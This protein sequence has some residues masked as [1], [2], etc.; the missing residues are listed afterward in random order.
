MECSPPK[1]RD[2]TDI[3]GSR[4]SGRVH[5]TDSTFCPATSRCTPQNSPCNPQ[6]CENTK[7][8]PRTT[9]KQGVRLS[10]YLGVPKQQ[11]IVLSHA[12]QRWVGSRW[13]TQTSLS[14]PQHSKRA[15]YGP[16]SGE[17]GDRK[18]PQYM[19]IPQY[20]HSA[21]RASAPAPRPTYHSIDRP[22]GAGSL[23]VASSRWR[24]PPLKEFGLHR[25]PQRRLNNHADA[26][27]LANR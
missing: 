11:N 27:S 2:I 20:R 21:P 5:E 16:S 24:S 9:K 18:K 8:S 4:P 7:S 13:L 3:P 25:M 1:Q 19:G 6:F 15:A 26:E 17:E 12:G 23:S 14:V 10:T 22:H